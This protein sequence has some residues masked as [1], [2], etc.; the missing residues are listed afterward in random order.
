M[1]HQRIH[2][3]RSDAGRFVFAPQFCVRSAICRG[4]VYLSSAT[5]AGRAY[6]IAFSRTH[7]VLG[8]LDRRMAQLALSLPDAAGRFGLVRARL[9]A[10]I[11]HLELFVRQACRLAS[12][13]KPLAQGV[14]SQML[15]VL[16]DY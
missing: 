12:L 5:S 6:L 14:V 10:Q 15:P 8:H 13:G 11:S 4:A 16:I 9:G 3:A 7:V 2:G 1:R